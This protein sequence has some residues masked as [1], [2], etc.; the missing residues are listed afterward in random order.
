MGLTEGLIKLGNVDD[1]LDSDEVN[2][3]EIES[4]LASDEVNDWEAESFLAS[5]VNVVVASA[6]EPKPTIIRC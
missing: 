3:W 4:F 2:E 6:N 1:V 5:V